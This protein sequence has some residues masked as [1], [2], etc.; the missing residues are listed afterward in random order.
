MNNNI[1]EVMQ[2]HGLNCRTKEPKVIKTT[3]YLKIIGVV[4][5]A[6]DITF[7]MM[8]DKSRKKP[9]VEARK[10]SMYL[11]RKHTDLGLKS[12]GRIFGNRD[13]S[14]VIYSVQDVADFMSVD[15]LYN[16]QINSLSNR[17]TI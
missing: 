15:K 14:T 11:I 10:I 13:H 9:I 7:E 1:C 2:F 5:K 8:K 16:K 12:I 6:T 4:E 3:D 17:I